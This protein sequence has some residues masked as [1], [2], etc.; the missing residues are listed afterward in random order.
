MN[1]LTEGFP[2]GNGSIMTSQEALLGRFHLSILNSLYL[3]NDIVTFFSS[4]LRYLTESESNIMH[5]FALFLI[6]QPPLYVNFQLHQ[7]CVWMISVFCL[8]QNLMVCWMMSVFCLNKILMV[9]YWTHIVWLLSAFSNMIENMYTRKPI[10]LQ[11]CSKVHRLKSLT[12]K[13]NTI[14]NLNEYN[15]LPK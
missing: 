1:S 4:C 14:Q 9:M 12:Q 6:F 7:L 5:A 10:L 8:N 2:A 15:F 3:K 11:L 13:I